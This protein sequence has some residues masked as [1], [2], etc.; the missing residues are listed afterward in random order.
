MAVMERSWS[1][2]SLTL[3]IDFCLDVSDEEAAF[4]LRSRLSPGTLRGRR[5]IVCDLEYL[6]LSAKSMTLIPSDG[7]ASRTMGFE[8]FSVSATVWAILMDYVKISQT[9]ILAG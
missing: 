5:D 8:Y 4:E 3:S 7:V 1:K 2:S 6:S 9:Q